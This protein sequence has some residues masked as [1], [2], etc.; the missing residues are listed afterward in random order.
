MQNRAALAAEVPLLHSQSNLYSRLITLATQ[1]APNPL[2][3]FTT[4]TFDAQL[5][6][7][8]SSAVSP[9]KL[10]PYPVLVGTAITG[11]ATNPPTTLGSAPSIP[12]T[13]TITRAS[14]SFFR[15]SSSRCNPATP[16]S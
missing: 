16:T 8:P 14:A 2:S 1:P 3:I 6:N 9:P 10:D 11:T 13:H 7:I 12:A 15:C 5:F 4:L